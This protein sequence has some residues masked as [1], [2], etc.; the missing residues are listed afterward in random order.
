MNGATDRADPSHS[1]R[2][3]EALAGAA[4]HCRAQ[5]AYNEPNDEADYGFV[6]LE[7]RRNDRARDL[8]IKQRY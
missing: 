5:C 2:R 6:E 1:R 8:A 7:R 3:A 4:E